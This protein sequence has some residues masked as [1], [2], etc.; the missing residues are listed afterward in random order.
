MNHHDK[1]PV[2][3][4][5]SP[6]DEKNTPPTTSPLIS[7]A[8]V[9]H[10]YLEGGAPLKVLDNVSLDIQQSEKV[11]LLGRSGCGKSTLLNLISGIDLPE[12]G[13]ITID[14]ANI[15]TL[16]ETR[17]T[18]FRRNH[19]G[20]IYQF[21]NL[22]PSL[23]ALENVALT[24]ELK[25]VSAAQARDR[26]M[27]L[28][29]RL[30]VADKSASFPSRLSGGEQQRI[31]IARALVHSPEVVLADEPTGNLDAQTG[32]A[33]LEVLHDILDESKSSLLLVTHSLAV[34]RS[35][36]RIVTLEDGAI[37][38]REGDFAW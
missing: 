8:N 11:A 7:L 12:Q 30:G 23:T 4:H 28:L 5:Q 29:S 20:F 16:T 9:S 1:S 33:V 25:G 15:C 17:R 26:S 6:A 18:L 31:A 3:K 22:I 32:A 2:T 36:N 38:E 27:A 19:I 37:S 13:E 24:L 10:S 35:A 34:A 21:F 14:G